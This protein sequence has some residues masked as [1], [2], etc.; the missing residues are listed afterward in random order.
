[1]T[2]R[3]CTGCR[4]LAA[5][6]IIVGMATPAQSS[7][8]LGAPGVDV[9]GDDEL[10]QSVTMIFGTRAGS[11]PGR[12]QYGF[13]ILDVVDQPVNLMRPIFLREARR[14]LVVNEPRVQLVS[15]DIVPGDALGEV[16]GRVHWQPPG[17]AVRTADVRLRNG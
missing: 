15:V 9:T 4:W 5:L 6:G 16:I 11:V 3:A 14:A 17:G 8:K 7:G 13:R 12:P 2:A 10:A 1:M